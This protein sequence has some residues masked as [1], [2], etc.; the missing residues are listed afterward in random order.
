MQ[1]NLIV[2]GNKY[3]LIWLV[4]N[5]PIIIGRSERKGRVGKGPPRSESKELYR[6]PGSSATQGMPRCTDGALPV[7]LSPL[8]VLCLSQ[9]NSNEISLQTR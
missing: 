5:F 8:R 3:I 2:K 1:V 6:V 9:R 4:I 7:S